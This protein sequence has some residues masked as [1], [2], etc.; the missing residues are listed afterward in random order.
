[1]HDSAYCNGTP[2]ITGVYDATCLH[3]FGWLHLLGGGQSTGLAQPITNQSVVVEVQRSEGNG[4]NSLPERLAKQPPGELSQDNPSSQS[5]LSDVIIM[6]VTSSMHYGYRMCIAQ[7]ASC[8][9]I[10]VVPDD[11]PTSRRFGRSVR[12]KALKRAICAG[13]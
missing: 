10:D 8:D 13:T 11:I 4:S 5:V 2:L 7:R 9:L 3:D 12:S 6:D 1:M